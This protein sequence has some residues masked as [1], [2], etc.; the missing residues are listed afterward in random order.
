[1]AGFDAFISYSRTDAAAVRSVAEAL[2]ARG[3][4][5]FLDTWHLAPGKSWPELL[6]QNLV[7]CKSV[8]AMVGPRGLGGWQKREIYKALD[9][10]VGEDMPVIPVLLPGTED[11]ALGF[12]ALNTWVD[13]RGGLDD[14]AALDILAKAV[15]GEPPGPIVRDARAEIC[16]YRGLEPFREEDAPFFF[17]RDSFTELLLDKI[18]EHDLIVDP[19]DAHHPS[20]AVP[21]GTIA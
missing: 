11:P 2:R 15:R 20:V 3:L 4:S 17:G 21:R 18:A 10:Q 5:P 14:D 6:E 9:R 13:L 12:L 8:V 19:R 7:N 16:P 1:M